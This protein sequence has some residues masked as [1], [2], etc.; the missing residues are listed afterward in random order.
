VRTV[1]QGNTYDVI[2][3][4]DS[5]GEDDGHDARF[6]NEIACQ[7]MIENGRQEPGLK[8]LD[9]SA[10]ISQAGQFENRGSAD[11]QLRA[12]RELEQRN[13]PS[14]DVLSNVSGIDREPALS[15]LGEQF[16]GDEMN[17]PEVRLRWIASDAR[18]MLD[19]AAR[20]RIAFNAK[21]DA[22]R[23][24]GLRCLAEVVSA[25]QRH[26]NDNTGHGASR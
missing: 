21:T 2:G 25:A 20:V 22:E 12:T 9:L 13:P 4:D 23:D 10:G 7:V 1:G 14:C 11:A 26:T 24:S 18:Q 8:A 16:S 6:A 19:G 5:I 15:E 3:S 17:L